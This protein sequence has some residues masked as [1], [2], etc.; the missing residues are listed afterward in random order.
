MSDSKEIV[1]RI[2]EAWDRDDYAELERL[3]AADI[4]NHDAPPGFPP[5][6][7]GATFG[8]KMF[9]ASFPDSRHEITLLFGEGDLVTVANTT[10]ATHTGEP[11]LGVPTTG[12]QVRVEAISVYRIRDGKAVEHWGLNDGMSLMMQLGALPTP[13]HRETS[14]A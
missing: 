12:C 8:H 11:F 10:Q 13:A 14:P 2:E 6:L 7:E 3:V 5:G 9:K 1:R 4:V